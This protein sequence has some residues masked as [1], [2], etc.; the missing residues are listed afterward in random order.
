M[1][2]EYE[3]FRLNKDLSDRSVAIGARGVVLM[4]F[5]GNPRQYEVEFPDGLGGNLGDSHTYT[6]SEDY[7]RPDLNTD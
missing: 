1:Y 4:V 2:R 5:D 7:M 6:I 3:T